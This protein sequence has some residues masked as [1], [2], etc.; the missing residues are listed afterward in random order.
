MQFVLFIDFVGCLALPA[1]ITFTLYLIIMAILGKPSVISL[2]LLALI[3]GLPA[4]LIVMTSRKVIYVCWM[5]LYIISLPVWNFVLPMYAYW[6][7][8]DFSWGDTRK[9]EGEEKEGG[10]GDKEGEFDSTVFKMKRWNEFERDRR[11][12]YALDHQLPT[13]RF[14]ER[15]RSEAFRDSMMLLRQQQP[16]HDS[17]QSNESDWPLAKMAVVPA[18]LLD[19]PSPSPPPPSSSEQSSVPA[20]GGPSQPPHSTSSTFGG[21]SYFNGVST[22]PIIPGHN[23]SSTNVPSKMRHELQ[24][25]MVEEVP[26]SDMHHHSNKNHHQDEEKG[27]TN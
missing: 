18:G 7:F 5:L 2:I 4:V 12:Q 10:H 24:E 13:P 20:I 16:R 3:L 8:D 22:S 15:P 23:N 11:T 6:H 14:L 19:S 9:V 17:F 27:S 26:L 21:T 25:D 1:A